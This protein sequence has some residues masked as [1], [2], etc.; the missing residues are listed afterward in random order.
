M[1]IINGWFKRSYCCVQ[2]M[3]QVTK[4]EAIKYNVN[5]HWEY[6]IITIASLSIYLISLKSHLLISKAWQLGK[7][8]VGHG[9]VNTSHCAPPLGS[10]D[11]SLLVAPRWISKYL[12]ISTYLSKLFIYLSIMGNQGRHGPAGAADQPQLAS[13]PPHHSLLQVTYL[14]IYVSTISTLS[15]YYISTKPTVSNISTAYL[16]FLCWLISTSL[17]TL[18]YCRYTDQDTG[19]AGVVEVT[20]TGLK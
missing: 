18:L 12:T 9:G 3:Q 6:S 11:G 14:R 16:L 10:S 15:N 13:R 19:A 5:C 17:H 4:Y 20:Y 7:S 2:C 1:L 8:Q